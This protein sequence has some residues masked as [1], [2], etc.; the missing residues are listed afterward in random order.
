[1]LE[2]SDSE[3]ADENGRVW[4]ETMDL[5]KAEKK[6]QTTDKDT[7]AKRLINPHEN[8]NYQ[9]EK[10]ED[11]QAIKKGDDV[12]VVSKK[13]GSTR[14]VGKVVKINEDGRPIINDSLTG[15]PMVYGDDFTVSLCRTKDSKR[16]G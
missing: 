12:T 2:N 6:T 11:K 13:T 9:T 4:L 16:K 15:L 8:Y 7:I 3:N 5:S 14:A 10:Y 1:L